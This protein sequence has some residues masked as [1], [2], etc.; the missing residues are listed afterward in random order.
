MKNQ[1]RQENTVQNIVSQYQRIGILV[2]ATGA[3]LS[4]L[5]EV[6]LIA[7][8]LK[9]PLSVV[10]GIISSEI[11]LFSAVF[12]VILGN[13]TMLVEYLFFRKGTWAEPH[14]WKARGAYTVSGS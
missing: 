14:D 12:Y 9:L 13:V 1:A 2:F 10:P 4:G 5:G 8:L 7:I 3:V 6:E 11:T